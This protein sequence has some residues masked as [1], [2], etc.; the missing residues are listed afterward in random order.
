MISIPTLLFI[1]L[2]ISA[3]LNWTA[4]ALENQRLEYI[5]K[6]ATL[7]LLALW[8]VSRLPSDIPPIGFWF[9]IGLAFSLAGDIFLMLSDV[10]F[11]KGLFAF[12]IAH[13]NYVIAFNLSH[14]V[15][16]ASSLLIAV[17]LTII[18]TRI[19]GRLVSSL[20]EAGRTALITPV[21]IY[22]FFSGL[23]LWSAINTLLR[24][25]WPVAAG[26]LTAIGGALFLTSDS[27]IAWTRFVGP[28]W[29]GRTLEMFTY[30]LAQFSL[31]A[32]V[33]MFITATQ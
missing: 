14:P 12:L 8:F 11:L 16:N 33:V 17:A 32:G 29:G 30:H 18:A 15:F 19:L 2:L 1:L 4:V 13:I 3:A 25:E 20:R 27:A 22:G 5:A 6:P 7:I 9:L 21:I 24:P 23:T 31:S 28:H 26:W 10:H